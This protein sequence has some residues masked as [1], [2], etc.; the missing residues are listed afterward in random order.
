[1]PV[2]ERMLQRKLT[3]VP[4]VALALVSTSWVIST[5]TIRASEKCLA[6]PNAPAPRDQ[7]WYYRTDRATN[8]QCWYLAPRN[9]TVRNS[10]T[11]ETKLSGSQLPLLPQALSS[12]PLQN[13]TAHDGN[14]DA[15][16]PEANVSA[17]EPAIS[18][19]EPAKSPDISPSL[20]RETPRST[21]LTTPTT[22][23]GPADQLRAA[24]RAHPAVKA[25][26]PSLI[27]VT[28]LSL[29]ALFGPTY[30][31]VRW[32]LRGRKARDRSNTKRSYRSA[33]EEPNTR[34]ETVLTADSREQIAE[35]LQNLLDEVQ[36]KLYTTSD[37]VR[38]MPEAESD[39]NRGP[40][41]NH[42]P[43]IRLAASSH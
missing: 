9:T 36:T 13:K 29:L 41:T 6:A 43:T 28:T 17:P 39:Q 8:R 23:R 10:A 37:E 38:P 18:W 31:A 30:Y 21:D 34:G 40:A 11:Q 15:S 27:V 16:Q 3:L 32:L 2:E 12:R 42:T 22:A 5:E 33:P 26:R 24:T 14:S 7:H 4:S 20:E 25:D 35:T 1:M 19:P